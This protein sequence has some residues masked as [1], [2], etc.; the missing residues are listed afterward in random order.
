MLSN[1]NMVARLDFLLD[2]LAQLVVNL[3]T[4]GEHTTDTVPPRNSACRPSTLLL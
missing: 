2:R 3:W 4:P 1:E